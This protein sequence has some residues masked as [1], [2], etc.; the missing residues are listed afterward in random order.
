MCRRNV[1][2]GVLCIFVSENVFECVQTVLHV[3]YKEASLE[4]EGGTQ[5]VGERGGRSDSN[6]QEV[7][8]SHA[9]RRRRKI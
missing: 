8:M 3:Y 4:E 5:E 1:V 9:E 7:Y 6:S 2:L